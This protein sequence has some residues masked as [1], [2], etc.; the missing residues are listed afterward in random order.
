M[1]RFIQR[2]RVERIFRH[3]AAAVSIAAT[4]TEMI[5]ELARI[6]W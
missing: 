3:V 6:R 4:A 1:A 5:Q 2:G